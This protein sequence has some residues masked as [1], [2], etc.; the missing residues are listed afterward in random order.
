MGHW[1][2]QSFGINKVGCIEILADVKSRYNDVESSLSTVTQK[3]DA[4]FTEHTDSVADRV[5]R[6]QD[7][8]TRAR[9]D[10]ENEL[11]RVKTRLDMTEKG[12]ESY[13]SARER[14]DGFLSGSAGALMERMN[15]AEMFYK[16]QQIENME[17]KERLAESMARMSG[18]VEEWLGE[19]R[20]GLDVVEEGLKR[21]RE[22]REERDGVEE[23]GR[24][25]FG[26]MVGA[27]VPGVLVAAAG[28]AAVY[29]L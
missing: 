17:I 27:R 21:K 22:A 15:A 18:D 6:A 11:T 7:D 1:F 16:N 13:K 24:G 3:Y 23:A 12:M 20:K 26:R 28:I 2:V 19:A 4:K 8:M 10:V 14:K 29:L 25:G 5:A 9:T